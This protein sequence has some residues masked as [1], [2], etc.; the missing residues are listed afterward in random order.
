MII[1]EIDFDGAEP[2]PGLLIRALE[3]LGLDGRASVKGPLK[4]NGRVVGCLVRFHD[5]AEADKFVAAWKGFL[6]LRK[7]GK[8]ALMTMASF[9]PPSFAPTSFEPALPRID[10]PPKP[11]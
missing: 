10:F 2:G 4:V 11:E 6:E 7:G 1:R 5:E 8:P 3:I 9:S